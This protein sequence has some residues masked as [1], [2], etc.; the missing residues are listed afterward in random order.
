M[1]ENKKIL[2]RI[3]L[4]MNYDS[5]K[6]L[7]EN[8]VDLNLSEQIGP[9]KDI[10]AAL[11]G[12]K[13]IERAA[14]RNILS[15]DAKNILKSDGTA[16]KSVGE[17]ESAL[18][19]RQLVP[20][21]LG[22]VRTQLLHDP[23]IGT[24]LKAFLLKDLT[25]SSGFIS[26]YKD[27]KPEEIVAE[28]QKG[29]SPYTPEQA[30]EIVNT[31]ERQRKGL[32][33]VEPVKAPEAKA[34]TPVKAPEAKAD[35]P[36][37][38]TNIGDN[39]TTFIQIGQFTGVENMAKNDLKKINKIA[40]QAKEVP[41]ESLTS[42]AE[43]VV[44]TEKGAVKSTK[45]GLLSKGKGIVKAFLI[46]RVVQTA[47]ISA[48]LMGALYFVLRE[49]HGGNVVVVS[50]TS[51][52]NGHYTPVQ[53][54]PFPYMSKNEKIRECQKCLGMEQR[55][56]TGNYGPITK[57]TLDDAGYDTSQGI[58]QELYNT[59]ISKCQGTNTVPTPPPVTANATPERV[60][61]PEKITTSNLS[62]SNIANGVNTNKTVSNPTTQLA[63]TSSQST[64][65]PERR[66]ELIDNIR[67]NKK[68]VGPA[69]NP[70]EKAMVNDYM[71]KSGFGIPS[72]EKIKYNSGVPASEKLRYK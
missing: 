46:N 4:I 72:T 36:I 2:N 45:E 62:L 6:T 7:N 37:S 18:E 65:P 20:T 16:F 5:S 12:L 41:I 30:Q 9:V 71:S 47:L 10:E 32:P 28:L 29:K 25:E 53:D 23:S 52:G 14:L 68:Y 17:F 15:K 69:L 1:E 19:K 35:P 64:I 49:M 57:Q 24:D 63:P 50:G 21:V 67:R 22:R 34:E 44:A 51:S 8:T 66:A 38:V 11:I 43:V 39:N 54:F 59:I 56:Q 70:E 33:P 26:K 61:P 48:G 13:D 31:F 58:T 42:G 55:Y 3:M 40:A 27:L 60:A